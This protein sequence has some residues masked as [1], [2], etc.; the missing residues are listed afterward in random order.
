MVISN[1]VLNVERVVCELLARSEQNFENL[2]QARLLSTVCIYYCSNS[3]VQT[4]LMINHLKSMMI[5]QILSA[6]IIDQQFPLLILILILSRRFQNHRY[7]TKRATHDKGGSISV[8]GQ[9]LNQGLYHSHH[10]AGDHNAVAA[11]AALKQAQQQQQSNHH[12]HHQVSAAHHAHDILAATV[13]AAQR[14]Q[15]AAA[16]AAVAALNANQSAASAGM[17][18]GGD[19]MQNHHQHH[20]VAPGS[21]AVV[22]ASPMTI[23]HDKHWS[24]QP[25]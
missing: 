24:Q 7:K 19:P 11:A 18:I 10:G 6:P 4:M 15:A 22:S 17:T 14:S 3:T 13:A 20:Q 2:N 21:V 23:M 5:I 12:H 9:E 25:Y 16:A 1:V 8:V